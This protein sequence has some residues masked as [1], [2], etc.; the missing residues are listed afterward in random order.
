MESLEQQPGWPVENDSI[1]LACVRAPA[2]S[3]TRAAYDAQRCAAQRTGSHWHAPDATL[4]C[5][6]TDHPVEV[7]STQTRYRYQR[8]S[9]P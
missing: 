5:V 1:H 2:T 4:L 8:I 6:D 3:G 9:P 7:P